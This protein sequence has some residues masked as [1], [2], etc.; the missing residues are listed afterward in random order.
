MN[1]IFPIELDYLFA[2]HD[3]SLSPASNYEAPRHEY[4]ASATLL[5]SAPTKAEK[6]FKKT[7]AF[8]KKLLSTIERSDLDVPPQLKR[9]L[10]PDIREAREYARYLA[11]ICGQ[12]RYQCNDNALLNERLVDNREGVGELTPAEFFE[13]FQS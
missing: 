13:F 6:L 10:G 8:R 5:K 9:F 7:S 12:Y 3:E 11:E 1:D 2:P 4:K